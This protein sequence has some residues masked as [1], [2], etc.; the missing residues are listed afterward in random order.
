MK[1][2]HTSDLHIGL[3]LCE[4]NM[5]GEIEEALD[6]IREIA[7]REG[8]TAVIVAGDIYDRA[9]PSAEA[10]ALFDRFVTGLTEAGIRLLAIPGN[11]DSAERVGYLSSLL[12]RAGAYFA[13]VYS[14]E[15]KP[16][17]LRDGDSE[18]DFWL[19]PYFRPVE[20]R[21]AVPESEAEGWGGT[22]AEAISRMKPD[23]DRANVLVAHH[24]AASGGEG[25]DDLAGGVGRVDPAVYAPFDYAALGHLHR[26]HA[27]G[28]ETVRYSGSPVKCSFDEAGDVKSVSLVTIDGG[29]VRIEEIPLRVRRDVREMRGTYEE[30]VSPEFRAKGNTDDYLRAILTDEEDVPDA[31]AKLRAVYPNLLRLSYDNARTRALGNREIAFHDAGPDALRAEDVFAELWERQQGAP[32]DGETM[33][34]VAELFRAAAEGGEEA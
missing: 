11:H 30:L 18:V 22:A 31:V 2:L 17:T 6:A 16:V 10:V 32:P 23:P 15:V 21:A 27:V 7:L 28:R 1:I 3:R 33:N 24:F 8:C 14:G 26:A 4:T 9:A 25:I 5:N 13:P 34:M 20:Y 12:D 29:D 19:L